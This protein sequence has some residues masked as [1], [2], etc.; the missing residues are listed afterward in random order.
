MLALIAGVII[1]S[2]AFFGT[3]VLSLFQ[4]PPGYL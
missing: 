3:E 1:G 4:I 2:V